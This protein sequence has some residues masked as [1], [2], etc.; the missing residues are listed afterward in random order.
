MSGSPA[1]GSSGCAAGA[2]AG[3]CPS[4]GGPPGLAPEDAVGLLTQAAQVSVAAMASGHMC[5]GFTIRVPPRVPIG[6]LGKEPMKN[7]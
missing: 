2:L 7:R 1:V 4:A 6:D 3:F 5:R